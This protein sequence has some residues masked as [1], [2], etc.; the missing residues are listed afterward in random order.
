MA[1]KTYYAA[2]HCRIQ[3]RPI[4]AGT[5]LGTGDVTAGEFTPAEGLEGVI[6]AGHVRPRLRRGVITTAAP[7]TQARPEPDPE[8]ATEPDTEGTDD[9][10]ADNAAANEPDNAAAKKSDKKGDKETGKKTG[11]KAGGS[12]GKGKGGKANL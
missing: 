5:R 8:P 4:K 10:P 12:K 9:N 6:R 2:R 1:S 7:R 11:K 3:G